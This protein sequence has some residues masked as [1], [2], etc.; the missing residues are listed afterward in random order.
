MND[1]ISEKDRKLM[2]EELDRFSLVTDNP[3]ELLSNEKVRFQYKRKFTP[4]VAQAQAAVEALDCY[5]EF[6]ALVIDVNKYEN[7][8]GEYGIPYDED[9]H[10]S[11]AVITDRQRSSVE[12][13]LSERRGV[14]LLADVV[15]SGK[16][17][18][19]GVVLSELAVRG[20]LRS[21]LVVV[22]EQMFAGWEEVLGIKFGMGKDAFLE[23][24]KPK[25]DGDLPSLQQ[26]LKRAGVERDGDYVLPKKP[27]LVDMEVFANWE[28]D[29]YFLA[30][31]VI[32]DEAHHLSEEKGEYASAMR[33]LSQMMRT[34]MSAKRPYCLL[35]TATPHTGNL[36]SMFRLWYFV[37]SKGGNPDDFSSASGEH[38]DQYNEEKKYYRS[39]ICHNAANITEFIRNVKEEKVLAL[40]STEFYSFLKARGK[41]NAFNNAQKYDHAKYIE[42]FLHDGGNTAICKDV[43]SRV[44]S[45]Y[46]NILLRSI[47]VR[48]PNDLSKKKKARNYFFFPMHDPVSKVTV[49]GL[50]EDERITVDFKSL[51]EDGSPKTVSKEFGTLSLNEYIKRSCAKTNGSFGQGYSNIFR[52]VIE[53]CEQADPDIYA[54]H[55]KRGFENYYADRL[56]FSGDDDLMNTSVIPV[57]Y[58]PDAA[59]GTKNDYRY[60][61]ARSILKKHGN[62][63]VIVFFDYTLDKSESICDEVCEKL[64]ADP[65]FSSRI[66]STDDIPSADEVEK[67]FNDSEH[68]NTI[69]LVKEAKFT[70]GA[71]YQEASVLL[72][73]QVTHDPLAMDQSIGRIFRL[74]QKKNVTV[75]SLADMNRL[76]G[77]A[78]AYFSE[79]GLLSG[80]TGDATILAGSNS[81]RM[82]AVQCRGCKRV[83]LMTKEAYD[84]RRAKGKLICT[85]TDACRGPNGRGTE[86]T[87][88]TVY[89]FK[90]SSCKSVLSRSATEGYLCFNHGGKMCN[91]GDAG[92]RTVFCGKLCALKHCRRFTTGPLKGK[93]PVIE[94]SKRKPSIPESELMMLCAQCN[95]PDC[96][97]KCKLTGDR[98]KTGGDVEYGVSECMNCQHSKCAPGPYVMSFGSEDEDWEADCPI[99]SSRK[100]S[101]RRGKLR[102]ILARTFAAFVS[103]LWKFDHDGGEGFCKNLGEQADIVR[104]VRDILR[105]DGEARR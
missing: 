35:L 93:C 83:E 98:R 82:V 42:E 38:T 41:Y 19:A 34:K 17:Y 25:D 33:L 96:W 65:E 8:D 6:G 27:L 76:E 69:L 22:P 15:G 89:D 18:E 36:E 11:R 47:M 16:T 77:F 50:I 74:G 92:D 29:P 78:L 81:D 9:I 103:E 51:G 73:Y 100:S 90:C 101:Y 20:K 63:R 1:N 55:G 46:H 44:S 23:V 60:A 95:N 21:L 84:D 10:K 12:R 30:D 37:R 56:R 79:I 64:K 62:E 45:E 88:I 70:E 58:A 32:I 99:C 61:Y 66:M 80:N 97:D 52:N 87:E 4:T 7:T 86:M 72:N 26:T 105:Q 14:G 24:R 2:E 68:Q 104:E 5:D 75:Y 91:S 53:A 94:Q 102:P 3:D 67:L 71:N 43:L 48:Q 59:V 39:T 85:E 13:F 28:Y 31:A 49:D 57:R 54:I 40:Y